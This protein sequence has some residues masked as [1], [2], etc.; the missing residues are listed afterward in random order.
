[1]E[2]ELHDIKVIKKNKT[3][4]NIVVLKCTGCGA[5]LGATEKEEIMECPYCNT[6][7]FIK[8]FKKKKEEENKTEEIPVEKAAEA[9]NDKPVEEVVEE[10]EIPTETASPSLG[11]AFSEI[12]EEKPI[13]EDGHEVHTVI[14]VDKES[15]NSRRELLFG[16]LGGIAMVSV[17]AAITYLGVKMNVH[18]PTE[19]GG[20]T[21]IIGAVTASMGVT[22]PILAFSDYKESA[23]NKEPEFE[24]ETGADNNISATMSAMNNDAE[25]LPSEEKSEEEYTPEEFHRQ[26]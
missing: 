21:Q 18:H 12:P 10:K 14:G 17:G 20:I 7:V 5:G 26:L 16:I 24:L 4:E 6:K 1:M 15:K 2:R 11:V 13:Y 25:L 3:N 8:D 23:R 19:S 22:I 9:V